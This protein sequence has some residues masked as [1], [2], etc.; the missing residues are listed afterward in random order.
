MANTYDSNVSLIPHDK[1]GR[2][3]GGIG[4][5]RECCNLSTPAAKFSKQKM[6]KRV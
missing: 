5:Y 2:S 1:E 3:P 6:R 4:R